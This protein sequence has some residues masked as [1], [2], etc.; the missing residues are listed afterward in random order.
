VRRLLLVT[1]AELTR[2][3]RARRAAAAGVDQ[4]YEVIGLCGQV[5]GE[6]PVPLDAVRVVRTGR[7]ARVD[8]RW[9][10]NGAA[11]TEGRAL[12]ELR[13]LFRLARLLA[14]S[15]RLWRTGR[16]LGAVDVVHANDL[17]TLPAGF[18]LARR[19]GALLVY[20]AHELYSEFEEPAPRLARR[21]LLALEGALARRADAVVTVSDGV[22]RELQ[23]RLRLA[24]L[25]LVVTNAPPRAEIGP[26]GSSE[27][28]LRAVYQ[29]GLGPGRGL[30]DLLAAAGATDVLLTIRIRMADPEA[31]RQIVASRG[32]ADRVRV[33][34]PV[35]PAEVLEALGEFEVGV[36][37]DRPQSRNSD[38]SLPNKFFEYLMAGLAVVAPHLETIGPLVEGEGLGATYAP[39]DPDGLCAALERLAR[40]R[41]ALGAMRA[42]AREL[43]LTRLNAEAAVEVLAQAWGDNR[44][45]AR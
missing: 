19:A 34:D 13:A 35:P 29:G 25:P 33:L 22:A 45:D 6:S 3:V 17:D 36:I 38:L 44:A 5:S 26:I 20:D 30:D 42:R 41:S 43:A 7:A 8:P 15:A 39:D 40:D 24:D 10:G 16:G 14:R 11:R 32:L 18:A 31:L 2:D 9:F 21:L 1:P 37:F 12:R 23:A 28:P 4:G 27:G